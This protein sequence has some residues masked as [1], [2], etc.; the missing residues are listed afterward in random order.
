MLKRARIL[1]L[2]SHYDARRN[3]YTDFGIPVRVGEYVFVL[4][5]G[6]NMS[7]CQFSRKDS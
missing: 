7:N 1:F 2:T 5:A 3:K 6:R 4:G